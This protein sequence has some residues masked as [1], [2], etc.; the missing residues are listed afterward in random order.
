MEVRGYADAA[1]WVYAQAVDPGD[2]N[3]DGLISLAELR[4]VHEVA[5]S[6]V[7]QIAPHPE[8]TQKEAPGRF[9]ER[10]IRPFGGGMNYRRGRWYPRGSRT[11]SIRS[12]LR[13]A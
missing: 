13:S 8:A 10:D 5:M 2:W 6:P 11:G 9:R 3:A 1:K 7:W 12:T 4:H